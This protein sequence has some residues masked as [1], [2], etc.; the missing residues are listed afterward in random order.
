LKEGKNTTINIMLI[1][2]MIT[3]NVHI[4]E[5][6]SILTVNNSNGSMMVRSTMI[7]LLDSF[8][9]KVMPLARE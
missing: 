4:P 9:F 1:Q 8:M 2:I 6:N 3:M 5:F 7:H